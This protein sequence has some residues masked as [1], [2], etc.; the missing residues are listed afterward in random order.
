MSADKR[1]V[2]TD[3]L[4]TLGKIIDEG[5]KRDAIHLAVEPV[6]AGETL[7]PGEHIGI[8]DGVAVA[9]SEKLFKCVGIVDP[10][11]SWIVTGKQKTKL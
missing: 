4:E 1:T 9:E 3:A 10:F 8:V 6:Q 2:H 5:E 11:L 7:L